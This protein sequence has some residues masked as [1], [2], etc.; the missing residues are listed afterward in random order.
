VWV[1]WNRETFADLAGV[2]L[3]GPHFVGS[4]MDVIGRSPSTVSAYS[5]RGPHPTP[6][7]RTY[8]SVELLKRLQMEEGER[9]GRAWRRI[10][11]LTDTGTIPPAVV[12]SFAKANPIVVDVICFQSFPQLG[13]RSLAQVMCFTPKNL[14]IIEEAARRLAAGVD[15]GIVPERFLIAASR[16]ALDNKLARPGTIHK[17]FYSELARR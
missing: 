15:P 9:Y 7:L 2:L 11:P 10:F 1:R 13:G 8:I 17:N 12:K 4:L 3:G 6:L 16:F 14:S 5:S